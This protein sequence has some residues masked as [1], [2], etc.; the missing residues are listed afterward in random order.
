MN[1][2]KDE[3]KHTDEPMPSPTWKPSPPE[4]DLEPVPSPDQAGETQSGNTDP[5]PARS[6][7]AGD[8]ENPTEQVGKNNPIHHKGRVTPNVTRNEDKG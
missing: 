3:D 6:G 2:P 8:K 7:Q 4:M 5:P 1:E